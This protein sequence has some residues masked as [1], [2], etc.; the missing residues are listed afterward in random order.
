MGIKN[1]HPSR[2]SRNQKSD[3]LSKQQNQIINFS[4]KKEKSLSSLQEASVDSDN[5]TMLTTIIQKKAGKHSTV[6]DALSLTGR[7]HHGV[8]A[9]NTLNQTMDSQV[10]NLQVS[11]S[12]RK[13]Q[14]HKRV[15]TAGKLNLSA[16]MKKNKGRKA[17]QVLVGFEPSST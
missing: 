3:K 4:L 5:R 17:K 12:S 9:W 14:L 8:D 7:Q 1:D 15:K 16:D 10:V 2:H 6:S 11:N 13:R